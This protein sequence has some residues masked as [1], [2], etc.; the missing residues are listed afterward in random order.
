[1]PEFTTILDPE[2]S[3]LANKFIEEEVIIAPTLHSE[4]EPASSPKF[5]VRDEYVPENEEDYVEKV[6]LTTFLSESS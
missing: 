1:M 4:Q 6:K 2:L 5:L 3:M